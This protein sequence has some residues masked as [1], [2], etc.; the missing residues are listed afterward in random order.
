MNITSNKIREIL[1]KRWSSLK[2][3]WLFDMIYTAIDIEK[4]ESIV[5]PVIQKFHPGK[6]D[7]DKF[8]M[9]LHAKIVTKISDDDSFS[10]TI[11]FGQIMMKHIISEEIHAI[12]ILITPDEKINLFEP[13]GGYFVNGK[14]LKPFFVRI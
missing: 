13:Q 12:N 6:F 1:K 3:I 4:F 5:E 7:C 2:Y 9:V 10:Q 14:N 8:A 11:T